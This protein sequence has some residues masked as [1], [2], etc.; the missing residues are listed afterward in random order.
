[1]LC[2]MQG[3]VREMAITGLKRA[4]ENLALTW[5]SLAVDNKSA[6]WTLM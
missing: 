1:M 2:Q 3:C 6:L 4:Q 5:N